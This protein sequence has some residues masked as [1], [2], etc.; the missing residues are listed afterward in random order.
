M[1]NNGTRGLTVGVLLTKEREGKRG[2][3]GGERERDIKCSNQNEKW[4]PGYF[5]QELIYH[6]KVRI[7]SRV[8]AV[9]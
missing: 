7:S 4:E 6:Q 9:Q 5:K 3:V 8:V 2:G 1:N